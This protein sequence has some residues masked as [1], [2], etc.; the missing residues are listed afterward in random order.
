MR[1]ATAASARATGLPRGESALDMHFDMKA[2]RFAP[3]SF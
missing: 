3:V 1:S 2:L